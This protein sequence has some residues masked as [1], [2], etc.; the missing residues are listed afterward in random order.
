MTAHNDDPKMYDVGE[1]ETCA[2]T[3][4]T[5][6]EA[7]PALFPV[8][9]GGVRV[10]SL[11]YLVLNV[12]FRMGNINNFGDIY[13]DVAYTERMFQDARAETRREQAKTDKKTRR[14]GFMK[15]VDRVLRACWVVCVRQ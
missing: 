10:L 15:E 5:L 3:K 14:T 1:L 9:V 13:Y 12:T 2:K 6:R 8:V 4:N 11:V 7:P